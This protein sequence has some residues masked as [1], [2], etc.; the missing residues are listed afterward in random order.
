MTSTVRS[1]RRFTHDGGGKGRRVEIAR[2]TDD[3]RDGRDD[4]GA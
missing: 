3:D 1:I 2:R 4:Q